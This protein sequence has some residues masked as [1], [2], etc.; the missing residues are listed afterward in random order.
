MAAPLCCEK[1]DKACGPDISCLNTLSDEN[2]NHPYDC[3][4]CLEIAR[5][6]VVTLCGHLY[7]WPCLFR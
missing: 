4:I 7:C 1:C 3:N 5:E 6:P 2:E